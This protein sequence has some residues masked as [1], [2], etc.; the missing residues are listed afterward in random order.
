[1]KKFILFSFLIVRVCSQNAAGGWKDT[2][3]NFTFST[4]ERSVSA[5][6]TTWNW[7]KDFLKVYFNGRV[8]GQF[9]T[10]AVQAVSERL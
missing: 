3:E 9:P 1:M 6:Y 8:V 7:E 5:K 10:K 2:C 4:M